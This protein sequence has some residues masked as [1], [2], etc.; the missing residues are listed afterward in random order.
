MKLLS[1]FLICLLASL[2]SLMESFLGSFQLDS[3][4]GANLP[5]LTLSDSSS[6]GASSTFSKTVFRSTAIPG[7]FEDNN[8]KSKFA[9]SWETPQALE[10]W[11]TEEERT[12]CIELPLVK[13]ISGLLAFEVRY[14]YMCSRQGTGGVKAYKKKCPG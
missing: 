11:L 4:S 14:R 12:N 1:Y 13:K 2:A 7:S 5:S 8:I 10:H 9:H 3:V 6:A